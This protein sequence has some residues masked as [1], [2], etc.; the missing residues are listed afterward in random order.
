[1]RANAAGHATVK[2]RLCI[3]IL[4]LLVITSC[5]RLRR[6]I[7]L[8]LSA[9]HFHLYKSL[10]IFFFSFVTHFFIYKCI[11]P[12]QFKLQRYQSGNIAASPTGV[13]V[14]GVKGHTSGFQPF[15]IFISSTLLCVPPK[16]E[17][18]GTGRERERERRSIIQR[19]IQ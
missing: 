12:L 19:H 4:E 18:C 11:S 17:P 6:Y 9:L 3:L 13:S 7:S 10:F 5:L 2:E 1:M 8:S 16:R 15:R 14:C